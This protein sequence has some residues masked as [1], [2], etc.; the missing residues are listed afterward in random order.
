[1]GDTVI[2]KNPSTKGEGFDSV[3][4]HAS[5]RHPSA[6]GFLKRVNMYNSDRSHS[7]YIYI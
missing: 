3:H 5:G 6:T 4:A 2:I 7:I 1:M